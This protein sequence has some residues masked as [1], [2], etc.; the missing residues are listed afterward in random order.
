METDQDLTLETYLQ[1]V[2]LFTEKSQ[3]EQED[4]VNLMTV[5]A[6]KGLEFSTVFVTNLNEGIFPN[7]RA[8]NENGRAGLEEERRLMYVAMTRAKNICF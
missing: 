5:H 2:A 1:N 3:D 4:A 8:I 6:A 7:E